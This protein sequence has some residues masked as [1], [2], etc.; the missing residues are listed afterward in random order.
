M[1]VMDGFDTLTHLRSDPKTGDVPVV[2]L[3][4]K[5][6]T[7]SDRE[8]LSG[9]VDALFQKHRIPLDQLAGE[10]RSRLWKGA[11]A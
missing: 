4:A 2:V 3:T 9:K 5:D 8:R 10:V 7:E 1:P 6:L 11:Q